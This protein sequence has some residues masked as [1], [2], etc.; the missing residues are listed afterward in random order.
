[1]QFRVS[2]A[3]V[4]G[5][6]VSLL[7]GC[8]TLRSAQSTDTGA[9]PWYE[10]QT[11]HFRIRTNAEL[12]TA[13]QTARGL[14]K[15]R[16]ALLLIWG[17]HFDPPGQLE[18]VVLRD[19]EQLSEFA[20]APVAAYTTLVPSGWQAV[21][22]A[23]YPSE[24]LAQVQLHELAH[25]LS[26]YVLLR[27]PRWLSEGL[28]TYLQTIEVQANPYEAVIGRPPLPLLQYVRQHDVLSLVD[29]WSGSATSESRPALYA[30]SWLWVHFLINRQGARFNDFL[31]RRKS[32]VLR[33]PP[34][35]PAYPRMRWS[36]VFAATCNVSIFRCVVCSCLR[37]LRN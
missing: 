16:M 6:L 14:E 34:R 36:R 8:A 4:L 26:R 33:G 2:Q 22:A 20:D 17:E 23:K 3:L 24:S 11:A 13:L 31:N 7:P 9:Q 19:S 32:L 21:M 10:I 27:Q 28:A 37:L 15:H 25:Y 5:A 1:M 18:I 35:L 30:S 12:P 29:V